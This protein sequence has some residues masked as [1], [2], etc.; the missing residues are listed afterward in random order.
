M[1]LF[2]GRG[3]P[4]LQILDFAINK[5]QMA[6]KTKKKTNNKIKINK[7]YIYIYISLIKEMIYIFP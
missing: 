1:S 6:K 3:P 4:T 2:Y 5:K 7:K